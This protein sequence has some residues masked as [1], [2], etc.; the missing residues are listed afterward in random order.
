MGAHFFSLAKTYIETS[1]LGLYVTFYN[2]LTYVE[3]YKKSL[4]LLLVRF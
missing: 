2:K 3:S 4:R 1:K